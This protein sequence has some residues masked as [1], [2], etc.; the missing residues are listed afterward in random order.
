[1]NTDKFRVI[2]IL[3]I[4]LISGSCARTGDKGQTCLEI[5]KDGHTLLEDGNPFFWMGDTGWFLF[6]LSPGEVDQYFQNR[7]EN[8]FDVIQMMVTRRNFNDPDE[9]ELALID[10]LAGGLEAGHRGYNLMT[11]HPDGWKSSSE[12]FHSLHVICTRQMFSILREMK[13]LGM[14]GC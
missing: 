8:K 10:H 2:I 4:I 12:N 13:V 7:V 1:M 6:T 9:A 11:I 14:T 3:V 5:S